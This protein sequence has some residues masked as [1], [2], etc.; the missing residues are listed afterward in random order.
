MSCREMNVLSG[1]YTRT[2]F[3]Y[4]ENE[5]KNARRKNHLFFKGKDNLT[6]E[7]INMR[8]YNNSKGTHRRESRAQFFNILPSACTIFAPFR[9]AL[10]LFILR[11]KINI[12]HRNNGSQLCLY[13]RLY[14]HC[15]IPAMLLIAFHLK[16][17]VPAKDSTGKSTHNKYRQRGNNCLNFA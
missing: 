15:V 10:S 14:A 3:F 5:D 11:L 13:P 16:V 6:K 2:S 12:S 7:L 1:K 4:L 8:A 17:I 9:R